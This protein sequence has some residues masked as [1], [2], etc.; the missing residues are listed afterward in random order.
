MHS[1]TAEATAWCRLCRQLRPLSAF[2]N[3][4]SGVGRQCRD[5]VNARR[6]GAWKHVDWDAHYRQRCRRYGFRPYVEA[7]T[8]A[9]LI[10][11]DGPGCA[12][13]G[14]TESIQLDHVT[15]VAAGG[16]HTLHNCRLL[17]ASCNAAKRVSFDL[18]TIRMCRQAAADFR[19]AEAKAV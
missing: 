11:R 9:D 16:A 1:A 6:R 18:P 19:A 10:A 12:E 17:C 14:A 8:E 5:C 3:R 13:C 4:Q 15:P 7:F 2:S